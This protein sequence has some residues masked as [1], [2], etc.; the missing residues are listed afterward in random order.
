MVISRDFFFPGW[1]RGSL[2]DEL[3]RMQQQMTRLSEALQPRLFARPS[4]GV[5][6]AVNLTED[7]DTYYLRAELPGVKSDALDIQVT[8]RNLSVSGERVV[9]TEGDGVR[10]HRREREGGKF[11]RVI[12]LP[13]DIDAEKVSAKMENGILTIQVPKAETAKPKQISV[14]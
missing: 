4:A 9:D 2:F 5:F 10:Y 1:T 7:K 8:G 14:K 6:P 13:T 12:G 11:S 3:G